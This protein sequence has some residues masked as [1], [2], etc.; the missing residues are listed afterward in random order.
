MARQIDW[1]KLINVR[2][3][4]DILSL[5]RSA[6]KMLAR[7]GRD[8]ERTGQRAVNEIRESPLIDDVLNFL[9]GL[10]RL[11]SRK[12]REFG[13]AVQKTADEV[14]SE[15]R[16]SPVVEKVQSAATD[17]H[18]RAEDAVSDLRERADQ[19]TYEVARQIVERHE[20][21]QSRRGETGLFIGGA[22][23]GALIGAVAALW[24]APQSGE[25]LREDI[26]HLATNARRQVEGESLDDAIREG[27][28][29]ARRYQ[30]TI[31]ER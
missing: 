18:E 30:E 26:E 13:K 14:K 2:D 27:K 17:L 4:G 22:L 8:F 6:Q 23:I 7:R 16:E 20:E 31:R 24:Y 21:K 1:R 5:V 3:A 28:A 19:K 29:E 11:I 25:E 9:D 12:T 10:T 15:I